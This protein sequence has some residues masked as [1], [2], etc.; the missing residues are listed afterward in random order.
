MANTPTTPQPAGS[1]AREHLRDA[2]ENVKE[3]A[4]HLQQA[5]SAAAR[6][7][8]QQ[9]QNTASNLGQKASDAATDVANKTREAAST[10]AQRAE[11]VADK[12][13]EKTD[14]ALSAVGQKMSSLAGSIRS[15]APHEGVIGS[16]ATT[17]AESLESGGRYLQESGVRA[18][19]DDLAAVV[20]RNPIPSVLA[21]FGVGFLL[22]MAARR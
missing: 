5:G 17:V 10:L 6:G 7:A 8:A 22:G 2:K 13:E 12:A 11:N 3:A 20:R 21:V 19:G 4:S 1:P 15:H 16:T 14:S 9:A 18:M